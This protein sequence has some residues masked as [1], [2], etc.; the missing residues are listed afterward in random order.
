VGAANDKVA[1]VFALSSGE[2]A[3]NKEGRKLMMKLGV[4]STPTK[5]IMDKGYEDNATRELAISL[6]Y[7]P[8]T[9]PKAYR[10]VK[11]E[12]DRDEYK[13]RNEVERFFRRYKEYRRIFTRYDKLDIMFSAFFLFALIFESIK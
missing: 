3:D 1:V 7:E 5:L 6:G 13:K 8:V 4:A 11:W 10:S 9:P 2:A 12:Y